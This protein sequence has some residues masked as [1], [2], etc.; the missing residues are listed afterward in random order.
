M[1]LGIL[2]QDVAPRVGC[3]ESLISKIESGRTLPSLTTPHRI[4]DA[5]Q[6]TVRRL[7]ATADPNDGVVARSGERPGHLHQYA[8]QPLSRAAE[9]WRG[10]ALCIRNSRDGERLLP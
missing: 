4:A 6:T 5:L 10:A 7:C 9:R 8:A 3:S 2:L 1:T